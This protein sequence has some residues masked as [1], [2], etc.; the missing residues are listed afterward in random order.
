MFCQKCGKKIKPGAKFCLFCGTPTAPMGAAQ[1]GGPT[2]QVVYQKKKKSHKL[3]VIPI[4]VGVLFLIGIGIG[5]ANNQHQKQKYDDTHLL[6]SFCANQTLNLKNA[7]GGHI[8]YH[9]HSKSFTFKP[10]DEPT[11]HYTVEYIRKSDNG[12]KVKVDVQGQDNKSNASSFTFNAAGHELSA[13]PHGEE[14]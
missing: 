1:Q 4:I 6:P 12:H 5:F 2:Q 7:D 10:E 8:T 13:V 11:E 9:M 14:E 3:I